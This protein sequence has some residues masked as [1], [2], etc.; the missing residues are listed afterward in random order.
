MTNET[1]SDI[2]NH[3]CN[4]ARNSVHATFGIM[5]MLPVPVDVSWQKYLDV[6]RSSSDRLLRSIDDFCTLFSAPRPT[7]TAEEFDLTLCL[8]ETIEVLNI[9]CGERSNRL[10][11][12]SPAEA[13]PALQDR[14]AV[15]EVFTRI[16][17]TMLKLTARGDVRVSA[18]ATGAGGG[19]FLIT[20]AESGLAMG[21]VDWLNADPEQVS[22]RS[23]PELNLAV[24][25]MVAGQRLRML[26]GSAEIVCDPG[27]RSSLA[28]HLP[29]LPRE[30]WQPP[31]Q[32]IHPESLN[33]LIAEDCDESYALSELLLRSENLWRACD[34]YEA[35]AMVKRQR[36]DIILMDVHMPGMDGYTVI[37]AIRE[38]ETETANARTPIVV[39][40]SDDLETQRQSAAHSGV[41]GFLRKPL[42]GS[43]LLD[44]LDRLKDARAL[45]V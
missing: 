19:Q 5:K 27:A 30:N 40:S 24:S 43:D 10:R 3:L 33:V 20:P 26:G 34:G 2:L 28:V 12:D 39:L 1:M 21:V 31:E 23:L 45:T 42:S 13:L 32:E 16:L 6:T 44:V 35:I 36:F 29:T 11:L 15:E 38:W 8:G 4:E 25:V 18:A 37:R 17:D 14:H 9:A 41:S 22:F 7:A